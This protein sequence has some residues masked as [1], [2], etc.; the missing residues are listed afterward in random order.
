MTNKFLQQHFKCGYR[1]LLL[2]HVYV[3]IPIAVTC[4]SL[5]IDNGQVNYNVSGVTDG[6]SD[7]YYVNTMASFSCNPG[8]SLSGSDSSICLMSEGGTW[9]EQMPEC[10]EGDEIITVFCLFDLVIFQKTVS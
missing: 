7:Y 3:N 2:S 9:N 5:T 6:N 10:I 8:Y 4:E 1:I